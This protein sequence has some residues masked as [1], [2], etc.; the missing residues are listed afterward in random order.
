MCGGKGGGGKP[1]VAGTQV[2]E[3]RSEFPEEIKPFI[4]DILEKAQ[5]RFNQ[6][7]GQ[8]MPIYPGGVEGRIAPMEAEQVEALEGYRQAGR[9]GLAGAGLSSARPYYEAGLSA[10]GESMGGYGAQQAQQY[11]NPYQQAVVDVAKREAVRQA[12]PTFRGIGDRAESTGAF[13]GSR[14]AIAEA[15]ANRNLQQQLGDIQTRG[16]QQAFEQGRAAFE[17]QKAREAAGAGR[18]FGQA[19]Q[20]YRQG[21]SELAALEGVG[22]TTRAEDQRQKNLLY[23]QF[24]QEQMYPTKSLSE[25]QS[26]VRGFPY[27]PSMYR[28]EQN[29]APSPGLG[30]QLMGG[31]GTAASIYGG[32]GGFSKGGFGSF[33]SATGGQVGGLASLASGGQIQGGGF[34][35]HQTNVRNPLPWLGGKRGGVDSKEFEEL[36]RKK[37]SGQALTV[38]EEAKFQQVSIGDI[39]PD[40]TTNVKGV[41]VVKSPSGPQGDFAGLGTG[42]GGG[43]PGGTPQL[44]LDAFGG[45]DLAPEITAAVQQKQREDYWKDPTKKL[46]RVDTIPEMR[47]KS[48][49]GLSSMIDRLQDPNLLKLE[50]AREKQ[51]GQYDKIYDFYSDPKALVAERVEKWKGIYDP[52][53]KELKGAKGRATKFKDKQLELAKD[54]MTD[55]EVKVN[56]RA[57]AKLAQLAA[58]GTKAKERGEE[59]AMQNLFLNMLLPMSLQ[60]GQD[61]R[62]FMSGALKGASDNMDKF[63]DRYSK[64]KDDFATGEEKRSR[65]KTGIED[66]QIDDVFALEDVFTKRRS[67]LE[68]DHF[69]LTE[70]YN[71]EIRTVGQSKRAAELKE[72]LKEIEYVQRGAEAAGKALTL[73]KEA[74]TDVN[75]MARQNADTYTK[76]LDLDIFDTASSTDALKNQKNFN[77][78]IESVRKDEINKMGFVLGDDGITIMADKNT[79][80]TEAQR[81]K[82]DMK[83]ERRKRALLTKFLKYGLTFPGQAKAMLEEMDETGN[84]GSSSGGPQVGDTAIHPTSRKRVKWDGSQWVPI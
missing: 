3:Q 19:P 38:E 51:I 40:A 45:K 46:N 10:L 32:M 63:V 31:L 75:D 64:L 44:S 11:M 56:E 82:F 49:T 22:K 65:E 27:Q 16:M 53:I 84:I 70:Q 71:E 78:K 48:I 15:E 54:H 18:L 60:G 73:K 52:R 34:E 66:K 1:Q 80:L 6:Q 21:L 7:S 30:Q 43:L 67:D 57:T 83:F 79:P 76:I 2:V 17:Q 47:K 72:Q 74:I 28:T 62:G 23:E 8:T 35:T 41:D 81:R 58:R 9:S 14:Q 5:A 68:Q 55:R 37:Q 12:Q 26:I 20:A 4:T 59:G 69:K 77:D 24:Q 42:K 61:P 50:G 29:L 13:G 39:P 33:G 36:L 25:Y